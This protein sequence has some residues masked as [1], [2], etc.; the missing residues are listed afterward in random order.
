MTGEAGPRYHREDRRDE[1]VREL[2]RTGIAEITAGSPLS[3]GAPL[4]SGSPSR[5]EELLATYLEELFRSSRVYGLISAE[6]S[7][8]RS[9]LAVR[10]IL[11]SAVGAPLLADILDRYERSVLFDLGSGAGLPGIPLAIL[12]G[13]RLDRCYLVER[14]EKRVRFL[15]TVTETLGLESVRILQA[16]SVRPSREAGTLFRSEPPPV[17]VF[18]AYQQTT[19]AMLSGLARVFPEGTRVVAWKGLRAS[20]GTEAELIRAHPDVTMERIV[21]V[22][23]PFLDRERTLLVF[24]T[25]LQTSGRHGQRR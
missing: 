24:N 5:R 13:E 11:D 18:R 23:V 7:R 3:T 25:V 19:D 20:V 1:P 9:T 17:V 6:D 16:D 10:H 8:D 22:Q 14:K 2:L 12:L 21:D 4:S 15:E